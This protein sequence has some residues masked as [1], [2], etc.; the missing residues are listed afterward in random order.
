MRLEILDKTVFVYL[1]DELEPTVKQ[2]HYP[3]GTLFESDDEARLWGEQ[4][5]EF[6]TDE[7]ALLP[8]DGPGLDRKPQIILDEYELDL[9]AKISNA[10]SE[11]QAQE[12]T[13]KL[14]IYN[15]NK[16]DGE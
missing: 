8:Q 15:S 1:D 14:Y 3:N 9:I 13:I 12:Y 7:Q 6:A 5:I 16:T 4:Y 10:E 11:S 2:P